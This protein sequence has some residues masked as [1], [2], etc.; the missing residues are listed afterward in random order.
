MA[1]LNWHG[2]EIVE[3][4]E[5]A[6]K[7]ALDRTMADC[8]EMA[9]RI[10]PWHEQSGELDA[11][12]WVMQGATS[13]GTKVSGRWGSDLPHALYMEIGTSRVGQ[14]VAVREREA[15][16]NMWEVPGPFPREGVRVRQAF[17]ILPPGTMKGQADWV[18]LHRPSMGTGPLISPRPF[19]RP[20]ADLFYRIL[21]PRTGQAFRG[22][23]MV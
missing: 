16:G 1:R 19:L 15:G 23:R 10:H 8:V 6:S 21:G 5:K 17:T 12:I 22:E 7:L 11:S 9:K 14:R 13:R 18:N 3:K 2:D 20:A 4:A